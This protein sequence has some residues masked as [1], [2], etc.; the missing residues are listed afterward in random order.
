MKIEH[1]S[2]RFIINKLKIKKLFNSTP[3]LHCKI[4]KWLKQETID[5]NRFKYYD[6]NIYK[7]YSYEKNHLL[8]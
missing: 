4:D 2:K 8:K 6:K 3:H 1:N 5:F 7:I